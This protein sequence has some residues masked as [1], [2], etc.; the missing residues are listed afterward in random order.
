MAESDY[1]FRFNYGFNKPG[2]TISF[3]DIIPTFLHYIFYSVLGELQQ[4][5]ERFREGSRT[6]MLDPINERENELQHSV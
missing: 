1:S 3:T 6:K 4:F 2:T 5:K